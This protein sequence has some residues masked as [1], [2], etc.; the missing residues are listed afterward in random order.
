MQY[1][2]HISKTMK[3][4]RKNFHPPPPPTDGVISITKHS[5]VTKSILNTR[6][7]FSK[8]RMHP[9]FTVFATR[10]QVLTTSDGYR[11]FHPTPLAICTSLEWNQ[12][13]I[14]GRCLPIP[15][16]KYPLHTKCVHVF[17]EWMRP[18][19]PSISSNLFFRGH[20]I[21]D[22]I[23]QHTPFFSP[24]DDDDEDKRTYQL[25]W[26]RLDS[27]L[28]T[29]F[30]SFFNLKMMRGDY[31][32]RISAIVRKNEVASILNLSHTFYRESNHGQRRQQKMKCYQF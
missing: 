17:K 18:P 27:F 21:K 22:R 31:P 28:L 1:C 13:L 23:F 7:C 12:C 11:P 26:Q 14:A 8:E 2:Q 20:R 4:P 30:V 19:A 25:R 10:C 6:T 32:T 5:Y 15:P 9:H 16:W 24:F 29:F 3:L